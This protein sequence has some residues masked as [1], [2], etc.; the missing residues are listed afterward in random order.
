MIENPYPGAATFDMDYNLYYGP[1]ATMGDWN[2]TAYTTF[3]DYQTA[4]GNDANGIW[5]SVEFTSNTDLHLAGI[6]LGDQDLAATVLAEVTTDI[7]GETRSDEYPYK[8]ADED[9]EHPLGVALEITPAEIAFGGLEIGEISVPETVTLQN[10]GAMVA[11][12]D[13]VVA[14]Q[15]FA[16][17]YEGTGWMNSLGSIS[18]AGSS[19]KEFEVSFQPEEYTEFDDNVLVYSAD[20]EGGVFEINVTGTGLASFIE[21][22]PTEFDFGYFM[23]DETTDPETFTI[24]N[25]GNAGL[26]ISSISS[27]AGFS[28]RKAGTTD[29][30]SAIPEFTVAGG[31]TQDIEVRFEPTEE[32]TYEGNISIESDGMNE[33]TSLVSVTGIGV[34]ISPPLNLTYEEGDSYVALTWESPIKKDRELESYNV[35]RDDVVIANTTEMNYTDTDVVN[36]TTYTYYTTALYLNPEEESDP[37]NTVEATPDIYEPEITVTP[38][39][40]D[41][42]KVIM[43]TN[44]DTLGVQIKNTGIVDLEVG[45]LTAPEGF[46]LSTDMATW[47]NEIPAFNVVPDD[48]T[49]FY[50]VFQP[51]EM[52]VYDSELTINTNDTDE[53]V[54]NV[55]LLGEG[56]GMEF[57]P[58]TVPSLVGVWHSNSEWGDYD[59]DGDLDLASTGYGL[60]S[61]GSEFHLYKNEGNDVFTE[62]D[63]DIQGVGNGEFDWVDLDNDGDLDMFV[64]GQFEFG[65]YGTKIYMNNDGNFEEIET[66]IPAILSTYTDWADYN[67]DG[68]TDLLIC[69]KEDVEDGADISHTEIYVN[70][71]DGDFTMIDPGFSKVYNGTVAWGDYDNDGDLDVAL[72]GREASFTYISKIYRNDGDDNFT[73]INAPLTGVRYSDSDWIDY[74]QDGDLDLFISGSIQNEIPSVTKLYR[75]DGNDT[76]VDVEH[77]MVGVRQG[78]TVWGDYDNDGDLDVFMNGI[79]RTDWWLSYIYANDGN[80]NFTFADSLTVP[81]L[82]Y[83]DIALG[84][85]DND[86]DL[87]FFIAG[88]YNYQNYWAVLFENQMEP[89]NTAPQVPGTPSVDVWENQV[90]VSWEA[91]S[92]AETATP[93]LTYNLRI[94]TEPGTQD[95]YSSMADPETGMRMLT[96]FGNCEARTNIYLPYL[97]DGTYYVAVQTIDN[98]Y[99][100]SD[101]TDEVSFDVGETGNNS[102]GVPA[103]TKLEGNYPNPF[104][105]E[106][107]ISFSLAQDYKNVQLVVYNMKGQ[108]IKTLVNGNMKAGSHE[109]IWNGTDSN[110]NKVSSGIYLYRLKT[111]DYASSHK[112]ILLK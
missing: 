85:Y 45:T 37:S 2:G 90:T 3:A 29:W 93:G 40:L 57:A 70:N 56:F 65:V 86:H 22:A 100:G 32:I 112:M 27:V 50:V 104:N 99:V 52:M 97:E 78:D 36:G 7:D 44:S 83:S 25:P 16:V 61:D 75:N 74:D 89:L 67:D 33:Q 35:Y 55:T 13:S 80:D 77:G 111:K 41:F 84:D 34:L 18:I 94:G 14:P 109:L 71:G 4:T 28:I 47:E 19:S 81:A 5:K 51:T 17:Q 6:S 68:L 24:T 58:V 106:T 38:M 82:K 73:D 42:G 48:S 105:P 12:V 88:R 72:S 46:A 103:V 60:E 10:I 79:Y 8:G 20:V 98:S 69:G 92:D 91:G 21:V 30:L 31:A 110:N 11:D 63:T 76:F 96:D 108:K 1:N 102:N 62:I 95:V 39:E 49:M 43:E 87:D 101:F 53:P 66:N 26:D 107:Q 54:V 64:I 9:L 23:I 15:G 59:N